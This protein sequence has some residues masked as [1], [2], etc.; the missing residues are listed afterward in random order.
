MSNPFDFGD[1]A[2]CEKCGTTMPRSEACRATRAS[3]RVVGG[4]SNINRAEL[5]VCSLCHRRIQE[6]NAYG[7]WLADIQ[8]S[9]LFILFLIFLA[10][11]L[12]SIFFIVVMSVFR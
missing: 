5:I 4:I 6:K 11:M 12:V 1:V 8:A 7:G 10:V 2:V 9:P 3:Y